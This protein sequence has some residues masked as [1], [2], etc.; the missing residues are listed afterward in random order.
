LTEKIV[1]ELEIFS[2]KWNPLF[3][4]IHRAWAVLVGDLTCQS[5][6][7]GEIKANGLYSF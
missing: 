5:N 6:G 2:Q 3:R 4:M 1:E 7:K